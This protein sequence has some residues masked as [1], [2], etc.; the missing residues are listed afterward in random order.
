MIYKMYQST[1]KGWRY[2]R[3]VDRW[4]VAI[5]AYNIPKNLRQYYA[6]QLMLLHVEI[7]FGI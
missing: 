6:D 4:I 7:E 3:P 2:Y 1:L 5:L